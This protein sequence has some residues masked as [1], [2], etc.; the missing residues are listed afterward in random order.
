MEEE[1][2]K[3]KEMQKQVEQSIMSPP[4]AG[5]TVFLMYFYWYNI[6]Y[7]HSVSIV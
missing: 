7:Y 3:L 6:S 5:N 4:A 2:E 1:A